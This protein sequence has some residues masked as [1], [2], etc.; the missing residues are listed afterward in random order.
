MGPRRLRESRHAAEIGRLQRP[1]EGVGTGPYKLANYTRGTQVVLERNDAYW[2]DKPHWQKV[3]WRPVSSEGP[4]VAALLAGDVD[5]IENPPIQDF[6]RIKGAGF[7]IVQGI[8]NRIIYLHMDQYRDPAWKT[9]GVKGTDK[10]PFL[11]KR[12]REAVSKAI[13]RQAIVE[14]IM[15]G[16][17]V[18][19]GELLPTPLFGT[20][21]EM[22]PPPSIRRAPRSS[23]P[24][25]AIRTASRSR[26]ARP[27]D[28]YINDEKVAQAA[29]Q[30]LD[31]HRHQDERRRDD[32]LDL[33]H[34]P[35]QV[36]VLALSRRL[37]R[38]FRRDARTPSSR[39][40]RR[41]TPRPAS[42]TPTAA[43]IRTRSST[44]SSSR[45]RRPSTRRSAKSSC[46]RPRSSR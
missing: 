35:Q 24:R 7:Q 25:P 18:A 17:A 33:L 6:D 29:A 42:A 26:S 30:M 31:P 19:A 1:G 36:R 27:N 5:V 44:R 21:P 32:G 15:G 22:K 40:S 23:S 46:A 3:T 43:A 4:R 37:G 20:S 14:R 41:R 12:V 8:S 16:V 39:S 34:P 28:R 13:N 9:P 11:D 45:R 10:N 38:G 2:G